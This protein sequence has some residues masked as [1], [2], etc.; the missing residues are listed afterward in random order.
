MN[1]YQ[2]EQHPEADVLGTDLSPI[3]P[4]Y[5]PP[6]CRFEVDDVEDEWVYNYKFDYIHGRYVCPFLTDI[7]GLFKNIYD[8]LEPGG[9]M[10]V[11]ETLMLMEAVD[12]SLEGHPLQRWNRLMVE[13][14]YLA[15][16]M[17]S[18][19]SSVILGLLLGELCH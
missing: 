14:T 19:T 4:E 8:N 11:M 1:R 10:E 12:D 15:T 2:A 16:H 7:P 3:Q 6:N 13:G 18:H 17:L 9:Y 5:V